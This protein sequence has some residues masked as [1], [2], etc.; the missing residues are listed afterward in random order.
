MSLAE[1]WFIRCQPMRTRHNGQRMAAAHQINQKMQI[2]KYK[3][4][5]RPSGSR[6]GLPFHSEKKAAEMQMA[7][8]VAASHTRYFQR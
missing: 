7:A 5:V 4:I 1:P 6:A 2:W 8:A 3:P